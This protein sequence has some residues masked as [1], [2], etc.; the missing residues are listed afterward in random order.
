MCM[1][2]TN[3]K[4]QP[5]LYGPDFPRATY[6]TKTRCSTMIRGVI[7]RIASSTMHD[8][9]IHDTDHQAGIGVSSRKCF[10]TSHIVYKKKRKKKKQLVAQASSQC[11]C[12]V[13]AY[14]RRLH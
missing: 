6:D 13:D 11:C 4:P 1:A 9:Y 7:T 14:R 5:H 3:H 8:T 2:T 10:E 12:L